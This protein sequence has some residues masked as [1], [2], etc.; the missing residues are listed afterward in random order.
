M[1]PGIKR[2]FAVAPAEVQKTLAEVWQPGR[3]AVPSTG[4]GTVNAQ[5]S[6]DA[7]EPPPLP[8]P[9]ALPVDEEAFGPSD[10]EEE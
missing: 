10:D 8:Q 5:P 6:E 9:F 1:P 3:K 7:L 2:Y 4:I